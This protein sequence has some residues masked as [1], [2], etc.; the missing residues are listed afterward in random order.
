[1]CG[2]GNVRVTRELSRFAE[3]VRVGLVA[4]L[5]AWVITLTPSAP[6]AVQTRILQAFSCVGYAVKQRLPPY[7]PGMRASQGPSSSPPPSPAASPTKP[8]LAGSP[9]NGLKKRRPSLSGAMLSAAAKRRGS[10]FGRRASFAALSTASSDTT[11]SPDA[12]EWPLFIPR[13]PFSLG[14]YHWVGFDLDH[15]LLEYRQEKVDQVVFRA[16]LK[17][18]VGQNGTSFS[19]LVNASSAPFC[20]QLA[21]TGVVLDL[22]WGNLLKIDFARR[23]VMGY[24]GFRTLSRA[25]LWVLYVAAGAAWPG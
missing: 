20:A 18:L 21:R 6:C 14:R 1:M 16:A 25:E 24:H 7:T 12:G 8:P 11:I 2:L 10:S 22:K 19:S 15:T 4:I 3:K 23:A 5:S 9:S 13:Q 17:H